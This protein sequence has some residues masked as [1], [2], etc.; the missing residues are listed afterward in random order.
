MLLGNY[1]PLAYVDDEDLLV[2]LKAR[3]HV[4]RVLVDGWSRKQKPRDHY[5]FL[6]YL[7]GFL[8]CAVFV[9]ESKCFCC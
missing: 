4:M 1:R 7:S 8:E 2:E 9:L 6:R 5:S 3:P